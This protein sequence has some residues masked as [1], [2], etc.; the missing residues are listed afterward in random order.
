MLS[1]YGA[2]TDMTDKKFVSYH[3]IFL[4]LYLYMGKEEIKD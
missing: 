2:V 1:Q 4:F 3:Y